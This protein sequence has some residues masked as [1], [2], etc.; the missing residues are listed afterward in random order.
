M[1]GKWPAFKRA[2][3][4]F[5]RKEKLEKALYNTYSITFILPRE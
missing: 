1:E 2:F 5:W 4:S 3:L